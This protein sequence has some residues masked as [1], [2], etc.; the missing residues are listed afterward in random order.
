MGGASCLALYTL[1]CGF[2][3]LRSPL[4]GCLPEWYDKEAV[5]CLELMAQDQDS[6]QQSVQGLRCQKV[7]KALCMWL[8]K[9]GCDNGQ[10]VVDAFA[11]MMKDGEKLSHA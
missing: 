6:S 4:P 9:G 11:R 8:Q 7:H 1:C 10:A 2:G 5:S 3:L